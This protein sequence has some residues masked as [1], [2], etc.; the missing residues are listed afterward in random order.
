MRASR[1]QVRTTKGIEE[2]IAKLDTLSKELK[3]IDARVKKI[4]QGIGALSEAMEKVE[5]V[6]MEEYGKILDEYL[7]DGGTSAGNVSIHGERSG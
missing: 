1:A 2:A 6:A 5:A 4:L 7:P 3:A